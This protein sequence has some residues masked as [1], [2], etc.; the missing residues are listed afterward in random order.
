[1][2]MLT[3]IITHG[4]TCGPNLN[5][6]ATLTPRCALQQSTPRGRSYEL[7]Q[8]IVAKLHPFDILTT[9]YF[10]TSLPKTKLS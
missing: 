3:V 5:P 6:F 8:G 4:C 2:L 1:M 7:F 9:Y 10:N